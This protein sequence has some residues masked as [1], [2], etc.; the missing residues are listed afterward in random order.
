MG[1]LQSHQVFV[2]KD[3]I[4]GQGKEV[5][6]A[7]RSVGLKQRQLDRLYYEFCRFEDVEN[8]KMDVD[9]F[10]ASFRLEY[11]PFLDLVFQL[12]D[13]RK[14]RDLYF[15]EYLLSCWSFLSVSDGDALATHCFQLFDLECANVLAVFEIKYLVNL[16][17]KFRPTWQAAS[18]LKK[19]DKNED[20]FVTL[21]EFVLLYRHFPAILRPVVVIRDKMRRKIAF[22]RFWK[23]IAA[24]RLHEFST[25]SALNILGK[26]DGDTKLL[27]HDTLTHIALRDD[28]PVVFSDRWRD[29]ICK[30]EDTAEKKEC[31]DLPEE[32]LSEA[33]LRAREERQQRLAHAASLRKSGG[34]RPGPHLNFDSDDALI[35]DSDDRVNQLITQLSQQHIRK[36][37]FVKKKHSSVSPASTV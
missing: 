15:N 19:L 16:V 31:M 14:T 32:I 10:C 26:T 33:D 36:K 20:G 1:G 29:I 24:H 27:L 21:A 7:A 35:N 23:E 5:L 17:H 11:V 8:Y 30:K 12:F 18:A 2:K 6:L 37:A 4:P 13:G 9:S 3:D 34:R 22:T 28:V 25:R